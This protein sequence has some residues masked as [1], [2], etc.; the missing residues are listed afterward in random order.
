[1]SETHQCHIYAP[2]PGYF[3]CI[4]CDNWIGPCHGAW[5]MMDN[6]AL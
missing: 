4:W 3:L 1:M 2:E 6:V 5:V